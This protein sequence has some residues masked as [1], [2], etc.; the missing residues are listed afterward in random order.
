MSQE[1]QKYQKCVQ[2]S[3]KFSSNDEVRNF[4]TQ[5]EPWTE[6]DLIRG[7]KLVESNDGS[8]PEVPAKNRI[9]KSFHLIQNIEGVNESSIQPRRMSDR[10]WQTLL[11]CANLVTFQPGETII[12]ENGFNRFLYRI[13]SGTV[14]IMKTEVRK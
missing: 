7:S 12:Q 5:V 13:K 4:L 14:N 10:D 8:T 6:D 2:K 1:F 11:S 3:Y 9:H